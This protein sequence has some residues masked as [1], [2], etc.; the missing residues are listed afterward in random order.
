MTEQIKAD[1]IEEREAVAHRRRKALL[2]I[3]A[4]VAYAAPTTLLVTSMEASACSL[5][6]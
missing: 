6:C 5:T 4:G 1:D 2:K 3:A